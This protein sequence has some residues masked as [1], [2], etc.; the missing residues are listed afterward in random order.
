MKILDLT[1]GTN[2]NDHTV[3]AASEDRREFPKRLAA[4]KR[5][6]GISWK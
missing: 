2:E 3:G 6:R 4:E 1:K 5:R